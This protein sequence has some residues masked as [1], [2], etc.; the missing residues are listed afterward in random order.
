[1]SKL[2]L[3]S[4]LLAS[5]V[6]PLRHARAADPALALRRVV[7]EFCWFSF[8]YTLALVLLVPRIM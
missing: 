7:K 6:I 2:V 8:F 5:L 4:L 1:M 3:M